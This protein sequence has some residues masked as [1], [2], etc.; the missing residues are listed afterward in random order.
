MSFDVDDANAI[1][2]FEGDADDANDANA[3][4]DLEIEELESRIAF[5][6]EIEG[7]GGSGSSSSAGCGVS[8]S[9]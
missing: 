3:I 7:G 4:I 5:T 1:I 2:D 9:T 8:W 6:Q